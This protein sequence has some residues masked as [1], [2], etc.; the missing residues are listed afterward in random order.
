V[1][2]WLGN[3]LG[4]D[5][6]EAIHQVTIRMA[7]PWA[8]GRPVLVAMVA[9]ALALV[10]IVFYA[11]YQL[12]ASKSSPGAR[13]SWVLA[14]VRAALLVMLVFIFAEP[15]LLLSF[16]GR[17]HPLL[18]WLFDG[19]DSMNISDELSA[20]EAAAFAGVV[21]DTANRPDS[22]NVNRIE[23]VRRTMTG[24]Q[25]SALARLGS[26]CRPRTYIFEQLDQIREI[27]TSSENTETFDPA[28]VAGQL[29]GKGQVTALGTALDELGRRHHGQPLAGVIVV[30]DF[31]QNAGMPAIPAAERLGA[32]V[33]TVGVGP[34]EVV[35]L[36]VDLQAPPIMKAGE[37]TNVTVLLRQTGLADRTARVQLY[38]QR[39]GTASGQIE[40]E[41][42]S[43][44]PAQTVELDD[45]R[46]SFDIPYL[47]STAGRY[48]LE[49]RVERLEGEVL[50]DNNTAA[51]EVSIRDDALR[52]L[53]VEYEPTWEW[54]FVKEVF[55]RDPLVGREGFR[56]FLRSADF[57]VRRTSEMFLET[58]VQPRSEFF[59]HDV[60]MLGDVPAEMISEN[61]GDMVHEY[62]EKFGG[63]LIVMSGPR[64]GVRALASTKIADMLPVVI[65]PT[66]RRRDGQFQLQLTPQAAT[67]EFMNLGDS[68][69]EN[70]RAWANLGLLPWFQPVL[71]PHP[72]ATVLANLP[73]ERCVDDRTPQPVI[74][75]RRYGKGEVVYI[76]FNEF[77]RLRRLY[78]ERYY[79]R[80][81]GQMI[82]RLG[83]GRALGS[84]KRFQVYTD[85]T[86]YQE[87]DTVRIT[88]EAYDR[89]FAPLEDKKLDARLKSDSGSG[90]H[91]TRTFSIP[92]ARDGVVFETTVPVFELGRHRLF[93]R[94]PVTDNDVEVDFK[95]APLAIE[96]RTA[97]RDVALQEALAAR[98]GGKA[99]ELYQLA[100]LAEDIEF[101][102]FQETNQR[103]FRLWNTWLVLLLVLALMLAE[104]TGRK[105]VDLR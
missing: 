67:A 105:L 49:V 95:V 64:F 21:T 6:L 14:V 27:E 71:R 100:A 92:L 5:D 94:D 74:A 44:S 62:V 59:S 99:Y 12:A 18:V 24:Q 56:T 43:A 78:G 1:T 4:I 104:W 20:G 7:A 61:F 41:P 103:Q 75:S 83:L 80:F 89:E 15:V 98:T 31:S 81:W 19:T 51:R 53:F 47:P 35:D 58:L 68:P 22:Q 13:A 48:L 65:D 36:S 76:G 87:G 93:V 70:E 17:K 82:N 28:H 72:L 86:S 45:A 96:R 30:S 55:H 10:A 3:L 11:R 77:W 33:Y 102:E 57:K 54:R 91:G 32:P 97:V 73:A 50:D 52:L 16:T 9:S 2:W 25:E 88:V 46:V 79:R 29:D 23:L 37:R 8:A 39:L 63:G 34:R 85:R 84:Q 69:Q 38:T 60:I 40:S 101:S 66:L 90:G 42:A 26:Q